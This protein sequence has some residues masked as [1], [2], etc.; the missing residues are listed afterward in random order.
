MAQISIGGNIVCSGNNI[1]INN[2][3]IYVDGKKID[4][5]KLTDIHIEGNVES[6]KV[7][8]CKSVSIMGNCKQVQTTSGDISAMDIE[9]NAKSTSG[10]IEC[11]GSIGGHAETTSGDIECHGNIHGSASTLSG[12]IECLSYGNKNRKSF[13]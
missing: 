12:D 10:D 9:G 8:Y 1:V 11:S 2:D 3:Q 5:D 6:L 4:V 7:D 13:N